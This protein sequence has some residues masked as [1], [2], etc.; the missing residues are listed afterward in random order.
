MRFVA[1]LPVLACLFSACE[2]AGTNRGT[3]GPGYA[4]APAVVRWRHSL[5]TAE[6]ARLARHPQG[7]VVVLLAQAYTLVLR[8]FDDSGAALWERT[9]ADQIYPPF[10]ELAFLAVDGTGVIHVSVR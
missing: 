6:Q 1:L 9:V 3:H 2:R 7:G 5:G 10:Q 8:R 4:G